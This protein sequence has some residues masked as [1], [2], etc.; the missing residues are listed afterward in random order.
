MRRPSHVLPQED[1]TS[2]RP[3]VGAFESTYLPGHDVDV[4]ETTGHDRAWRPD[5]D[6]L[7]DAGISTLRYPLRWHRTE[8][9]P[10]HFVWDEADAVLEHLRERGAHVVVD[11]VHH[12]S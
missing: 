12:T 7:L 4:A 9:E 11:L 8:P 1:L 3:F 5:L 6:R 10:G 2:G